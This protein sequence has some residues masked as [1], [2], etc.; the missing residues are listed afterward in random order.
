MFDGEIVKKKIPLKQ[1][2]LDIANFWPRQSPI[3]SPKKS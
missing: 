2:N 3:Q 1:N